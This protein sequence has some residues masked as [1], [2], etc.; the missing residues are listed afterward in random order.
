MATDLHEVLGQAIKSPADLHALLLAAKDNHVF[1]LMS[2][3]SWQNHF[4]PSLYLALDKRK[5][6]LSGGKGSRPQSIPLDDFTVLLST[7]DEYGLLQPLRDR[8]RLTL[9]FSYYSPEDL[10]V[11]VRQRANALG[12]DIDE[13][14]PPSHCHSFAGNTAFGTAA[15]AILP[16]SVPR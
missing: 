10:A 1:T 4:K 9:R 3:T 16:P 13:Y 8:M 11:V 14:L 15:T 6:V 2:A 12:W 7:T 5:I